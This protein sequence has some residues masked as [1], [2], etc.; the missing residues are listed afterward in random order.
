MHGS[1][2]HRSRHRPAPLAVGVLLSLVLAAPPVAAQT[3]DLR[4]L[5][6]GA[7]AAGVLVSLVDS[8]GATI[9]RGLTAADGMA[10]LRAEPGRYL[11]RAELIG[12]RATETPLFTLAPGDAVTR[13]LT[14]LAQPVQLAGIEATGAQR[15]ELRALPGRDVH[16]VWN[17]AR[18]ALEAEQIGRSGAYYRFDI[19]HFAREVATP[20]PRVLRD[21]RRIASNL[22]SNPFRSLPAE[23]LAS[24]GYLNVTGEG[25]VL[26][27]PTPDVLLSDSFLDAH[28]FRLVRDE[29][30]EP[31]ALGL[32]FE[33]VREAR[34]TDVAGTLW[35]DE[36]T[37][38]LRRLE[39]RY[40]RLPSRLPEGPYGG[41]ASF[42][43]LPSGV[44]IV[45][46]WLIRSPLLGTTEGNVR[47]FRTVQRGVVAA[48][49]EGAQILRI[50][51]P[52]GTVIDDAARAALV[53]M[54]RDDDGSPLVGAT[55]SIAGTTHSATTDPDG[56]F[57]F[58]NLPAGDFEIVVEP[59]AYLGHAPETRVVAL[60]SGESTEVAFVFPAVARTFADSAALVSSDSWFGA[61][62][63]EQRRERGLGLLYITLREIELRRIEDIAKLID[64]L[65]EAKVE[66]SSDGGSTLLL[67][68]LDGQPC[69]ADVYLNGSEVNAGRFTWAGV[70]WDQRAT[71]PLRFD[72]L[73][74]P[75]Q[76][77][78]LELYGAAQTPVA[79]ESGC[80]TLLLWSSFYRERVDERL[81]GSIQG[82]A[83]DPETGRPITTA[84]IRI[85]ALDIAVQ[86]DDAGR[87]R[88]TDLPPGEYR[89]DVVIPNARPWS[90]T[91]EVKAFGVVNVDLEIETT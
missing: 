39:F 44:W 77:D 22:S 10:R 67:D 68:G 19:E 21:D 5:A 3:I 51:T 53:G 73:L 36:E 20:R 11:V 45:Q 70:R 27:A 91:V 37:A 83:T 75:E 42:R 74:T 49:E 29:S 72:D 57:R 55:V 23:R 50:S 90:A 61:T 82:T 7:P 84:T 71:R 66:R 2:A 12:R 25:D 43:R 81:L 88:I 60:A 87:F 59:R 8:A 86:P 17:E 52:D 6:E 30:R 14:L 63:F 34:N 64:D 56:R 85:R 35:L 28:C 79:S 33:P 24:D 40:V 18:K 13:T 26:Y 9:A 15:C 46:D 38:E 58:G 89:L 31:A 41:E 16:T 54:V 76:I 1:P 80:G 65:P 62:G 32:S 47:G 48:Y 4:V 69:A 78:G